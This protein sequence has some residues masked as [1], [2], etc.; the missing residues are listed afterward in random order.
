MVKLCSSRTQR[1]GRGKDRQMGTEPNSVVHSLPYSFRCALRFHLWDASSDQTSKY[2]LCCGDT[3]VNQTQ[4]WP[5]RNS[6]TRKG[7][8]MSA[9]TAIK[10]TGSK[11]IRHIQ[12]KHLGRLQ[13]GDLKFHWEDS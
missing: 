2:W 3:D 10:S 13:E 7:D 9:V 4:F 12:V 1:N 8:E 6:R 11:A 5:S